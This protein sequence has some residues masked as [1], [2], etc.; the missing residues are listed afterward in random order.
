MAAWKA[1]LVFGLVLSA[2]L[3][4][5]HAADK[6]ASEAEDA[7]DYADEERAHLL[8]RKWIKDETVVQGRNITIEL[9]VHNAGNM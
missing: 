2:G 1:V 4:Q 9:E 3:M 6:A 7:D 5:A 8:V